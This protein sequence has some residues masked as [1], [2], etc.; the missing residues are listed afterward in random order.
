MDTEFQVYLHTCLFSSSLW[1]GWGDFHVGD[2]SVS[3]PPPWKPLETRPETSLRGAE[4]L[5]LLLSLN[6]RSWDMSVLGHVCLVLCPSS[7]ALSL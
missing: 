5:F 3:M 7:V 2:V 4:C 1:L 6:S